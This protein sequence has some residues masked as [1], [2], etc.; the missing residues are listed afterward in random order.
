MTVEQPPTSWT[1]RPRT[2]Y[3]AEANSFQE[4]LGRIEEADSL[5]REVE[6]LYDELV[7]AIEKLARAE[8]ET[9]RRRREWRKAQ[10]DAW[11]QEEEDR[12]AERYSDQIEKTEKL[13]ERVNRL[14]ERYGEKADKLVRHFVPVVTTP[15]TPDLSPPDESK[16]RLAIGRPVGAE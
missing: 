11:T 16:I 3:L 15:H 6:G 13:R 1:W 9:E 2:E 4:L 5:P 7:R 10:R 8:K 12:A 14:R